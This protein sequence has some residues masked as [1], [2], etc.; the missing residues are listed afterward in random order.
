MEPGDRCTECR[1]Q[2][3]LAEWL[4]HKSCHELGLPCE[5]SVAPG[6]TETTDRAVPFSAVSSCKDVGTRMIRNLRIREDA[7]QRSP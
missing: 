7:T 5:I 2:L 6:I 4:L 3:S 1:D